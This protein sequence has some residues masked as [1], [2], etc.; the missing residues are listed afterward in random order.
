MLR[1][2]AYLA[3]FVVALLAA[4]RIAG[5]LVEAL[6]LAAAVIATWLL[7]KFCK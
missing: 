1:R 4:W 7:I 3:A 5:V 2:L 6:L